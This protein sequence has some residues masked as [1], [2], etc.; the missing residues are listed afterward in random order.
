MYRLLL[1]LP[2]ILS[3]HAASAFSDANTAQVV[4]TLKEGRVTCGRLETVYQFDCYRQVYRKAGSALQNRPD[5]AGARDALRDIERTLDKV[6]KQNR[7]R[8]KPVL[9]VGGMRVKPIRSETMPAAIKSFDAARS[10]AVT[11]LLRADGKAKIHYTRIADVVG[12]TKVLIRSRL[13]TLFAALPLSALQNDRK[14]I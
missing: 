8:N 1:A 2:L 3:A 4:N 10:T 13:Q 7:D 14:T 12:S 9:N 11:K 6:V 5:Y